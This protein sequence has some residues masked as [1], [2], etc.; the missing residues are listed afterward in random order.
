MIKLRLF[1]RFS[2]LYCITALCVIFTNLLS[3][4][5]EL[6]FHEEQPFH[7]WM[8]FIQ[9]NLA[10]MLANIGPNNKHHHL[11]FPFHTHL[12]Q[13]VIQAVCICVKEEDH[14]QKEERQNFF[15]LTEFSKRASMLKSNAENTKRSNVA[16]L[17]TKNKFQDQ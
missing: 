11:H 17:P 4:V 7:D 12:M 3:L 13:S 15:Y 5:V 8:V 14:K 9:V 2:Y 10:I 1:T 16:I 6:M